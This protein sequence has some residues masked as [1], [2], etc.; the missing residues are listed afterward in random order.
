MLDA[1]GTGSAGPRQL[2]AKMMEAE[3]LGASPDFV[4]LGVA[5]AGSE[6]PGPEGKV[7]Y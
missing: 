4:D 3:P 1:Q 5:R 7:C 6:S 2:Q